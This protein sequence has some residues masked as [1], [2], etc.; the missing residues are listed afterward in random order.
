M[1]QAQQSGPILDPG[2]FAIQIVDLEVRGRNRDAPDLY[3]VVFRLDRSADPAWIA[4]FHELESAQG[5]SPF[6][7]PHRLKAGGSQIVWRASEKEIRGDTRWV[8]TC[9]DRA[10]DRF[11]EKMELE[12]AAKD[13]EGR[14]RDAERQKLAELNEVLRAPWQRT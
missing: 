2:Q 12:L 7:D 14:R 9:V 5:A 8:G 3:D 6:H 4:I 10:N 1:L 11:R 13:A